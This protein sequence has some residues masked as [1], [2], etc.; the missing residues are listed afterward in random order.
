MITLS[1]LG[2]GSDERAMVGPGMAGSI[3]TVYSPAKFVKTHP[4]TSRV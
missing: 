4:R 1:G 3:G 2:F